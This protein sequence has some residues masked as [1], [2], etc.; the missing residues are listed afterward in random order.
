MLAIESWHDLLQPRA[1]FET[2][3]HSR[4]RDRAAEHR[5]I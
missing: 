1:G 5:Q 3:A 4:E 2:G